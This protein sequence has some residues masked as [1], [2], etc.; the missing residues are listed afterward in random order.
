MAPMIAMLITLFNGSSRRPGTG[1]IRIELLVVGA[2]CI[3]I[4]LLGFVCACYALS[5][6]SQRG[7]DKV[8]IPAMIGLIINGLILLGGVALAVVM[9]L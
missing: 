6:V 3:L 8:F 1:P 7:Y 5:G 9:F 4:M 2:S